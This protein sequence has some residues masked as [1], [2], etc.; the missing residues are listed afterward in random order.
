MCSGRDLRGLPEPRRAVERKASSVFTYVWMMVLMKAL[1]DRSVSACDY[2]A[3]KEFAGSI[4]TKRCRS[5]TA[6]RFRMQSN[7][8]I[9]LVI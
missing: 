2:G 4:R 1:D 6:S 5:D 3:Q 9:R 7:G 8:V